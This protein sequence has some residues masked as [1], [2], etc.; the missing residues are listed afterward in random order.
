MAHVLTLN[1]TSREA[2]GSRKL[3]AL[4]RQGLLPGVVYGYKVADGMLV[5]VERRTFEQVY[6]RAGANS[7]I[8]LRLD[9]DGT[10]TKVFVH[11]IQRHPVN[12]ALLHVDFRAVNMDEPITAEVALILVGE[13]PAVRDADGM[14]MQVLETLHIRALPAHI[15]SN[16][17]VDV[18][19]LS[20][21]GQGINVGD[22]QLPA[23]V[24]VLTD[25]ELHVVHIIASQKGTE[26]EEAATEAAE[27]EAA[28]AGEA[29]AEGDDEG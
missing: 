15:P 14:V 4:R 3:H 24:E 26:E 6:R 18:S 5:Q 2:R 13:A 29:G 1:V 21:V 23:E 8:D 17:E 20:E 28:E 25:P 9:A 27:A 10:A 22:L 12:H 16:I 19:R 11:E 7:L